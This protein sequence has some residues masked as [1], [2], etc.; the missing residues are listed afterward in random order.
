MHV[1]EISRLFYDLDVPP[2]IYRLD[3]SHYELAHVLAK[4][5]DGWVVFL[6]ERASESSPVHFTSEHNACIYLLGCV[7][8][9][10]ADRRRI[11]IRPPRQT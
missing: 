8:R 7:F 1:A 9:E 3:G 4:R 2:D 5:D 10:L 6:S 11:Q